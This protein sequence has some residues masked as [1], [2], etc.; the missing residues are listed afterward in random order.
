MPIGQVD[1]EPDYLGLLR[2]MCDDFDEFQ[3]RESYK[4]NRKVRDP[5]QATLLYGLN[6]HAHYMARRCL[7]IL[8]E[9]TI[10]A[11]PIVRSVFECG[12]MAQ[13]LRWVPGSEMTLMDDFDRQMGWVIDDFE[14]SAEPDWRE[15]ATEL[16]ARL[17]EIPDLSEEPRGAY[18]ATKFKKICEPFYGGTDLYVRYRF[19]SAHTHAGAQVASAWLGRNAAGW[20]VLDKPREFLSFE[21][22]GRIV[23]SALGFS[24]RAFDDLVAKSPRSKF[25]DSVEQRAQVSTW[26]QMKT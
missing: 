20:R 6:A 9:S 14:T 23:I 17:T 5:A 21:S 10:A 12:V 16:R 26:L 7:P 13:W 18:S 3:Q 25:L 8:A 15:R 4:L 24:S 11:V 22:V 19:L 2:E 1:G